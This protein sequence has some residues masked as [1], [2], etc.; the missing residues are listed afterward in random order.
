MADMIYGYFASQI[1]RT[2]VEL[3][4]ADHL[5]DGPRSTDEIAE[6][7]GAEPVVVAR[8]LRT[9]IVYGLI[10]VDADGRHH[11]TPLTETLQSSAPRSLRGMALGATNNSHWTPWSGLPGAA[12]TGQCQSEAKLGM[13]SFDYLAQN[14]VEAEEFTAYMES[15]TGLWAIDLARVIDT[16]GVGLAIDV[17]G[18]NGALLRELRVA[19][20]GLRGVV[21]DRP[22]VATAVAP[23]VAESGESDHIQ[24]IGGDFFEGVPAGDLYLLKFILH[25]W[26]DDRCVQILSRCRE[27]M[28]PGARVVII[29]MIV[30]ES[31]D[32][33]VAALMDLN[34]LVV[35]GGRERSITEYDELL[36]R[37]G[38]QRISVSNDS[39]PQGVIESV[40]L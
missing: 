26:D 31:N 3:S 19:N 24:V 18:A 22:D 25:D 6:R 5:A 23:V 2:F 8:L 9:G 20:P 14:P 29:E 35:T 11:G 30:G 13:P 37:A 17:G 16:E 39:P 38:L 34:M 40:A 10:E 28:R 12:R 32:P 33:G 27:A 1:V 7:T 21:F 36:K 4:I 15:L